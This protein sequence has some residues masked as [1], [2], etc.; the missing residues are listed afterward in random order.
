MK[1]YDYDKMIKQSKRFQKSYKAPKR[2][3]S[4]RDLLK[5]IN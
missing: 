1:T 5:N 3:K 2:A 4:L